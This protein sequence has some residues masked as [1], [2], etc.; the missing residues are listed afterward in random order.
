MTKMQ[1]TYRLSRAL[2]D[3]DLNQISRLH[4][5]Y[6]IFQAQ[7][8]PSLDELFV[9]YDATRFS[10]DDVKTVLERHGIPLATN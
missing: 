5:V 9:E 3:D 2:G 7:V 8:R 6:G 10:S 4:S 1:H